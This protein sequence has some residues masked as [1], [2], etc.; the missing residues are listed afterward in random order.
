MIFGIDVDELRLAR[1]SS[2]LRIQVGPL[3][4]LGIFIATGKLRT[5][6]RTPVGKVEEENCG[7]RTQRFKSQVKQILT[8]STLSSLPL[9]IFHCRDTNR[10]PK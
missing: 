1:I 5:K 7:T 8:G 10:G 9:Y 6:D 3:I 4:Y 2:V